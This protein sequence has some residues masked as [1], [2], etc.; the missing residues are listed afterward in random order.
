MSSLQS[1]DFWRVNSSGEI[2]KGFANVLL[3]DA[4]PTS[5][6]DATKVRKTKTC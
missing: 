2:N 4:I 6:F 1:I 3:A 5:K